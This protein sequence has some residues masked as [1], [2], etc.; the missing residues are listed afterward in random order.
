LTE[1]WVDVKRG[2]KLSESDLVSTGKHS[3]IRL[4]REGRYFMLKS[5]SALDLGSIR[6]ISLNDLLLELAREEIKEIPKQKNDSDIKST[7]VYG[8]E[9]NG[10]K[11]KSIV[12]S[13]LGIRKLNGAKQLA[14]AGYRESSIL[15]AKET[16]RKF[17]YTRQLVPDRIYFADL[18]EKLSLYE[19]AYKEYEKIIS[20]NLTEKEKQRIKDKLE[21][22]SKKLS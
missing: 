7:A 22:L 15:V 9:I 19:E 10:K 2:D 18:L 17:P 4:R 14:E 6:K 21:E 13:E 3:Y 11:D 5:N 16:Y 1:N 12:A 20:M 8:T